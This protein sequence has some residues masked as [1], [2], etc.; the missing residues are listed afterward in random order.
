MGTRDRQPDPWAMD[1]REFLRKKL[2]GKEVVVNMEYNRKI[3]LASAAEVALNDGQNERIISCANVEL[4]G[5]WRA[6]VLCAVCVRGK[7]RVLSLGAE[8]AVFDACGRR[9]MQ[10]CALHSCFA[11]GLCM[12]LARSTA[13]QSPHTHPISPLPP[14]PPSPPRRLRGAQ[15]RQ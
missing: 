5:G 11:R 1:G 14:P 10:C 13:V 3:P 2:I 7:L 15:E 9:W 12:T 8:H 6:G 4:A